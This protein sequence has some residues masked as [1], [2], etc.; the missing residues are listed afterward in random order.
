MPAD[1]IEILEAAHAAEQRRI[2]SVGARIAALLATLD[3]DGA[4]DSVVP[5]ASAL[6]TGASASPNADPGNAPSGRRKRGHRDGKRQRR[7]EQ[8]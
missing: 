6:G 1:A 4:W 7:E 3:A 2:D 8:V 5:G